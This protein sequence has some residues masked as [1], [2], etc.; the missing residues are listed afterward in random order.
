[1]VTVTSND[2]RLKIGSIPTMVTGGDEVQNLTRSLSVQSKA[3]IIIGY[4]APVTIQTYA[5]GDLAL[6]LSLHIIINENSG[7]ISDMDLLI[8]LTCGEAE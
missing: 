5:S 8:S 7:S 6:S 2:P 4:G 3:N 1:M